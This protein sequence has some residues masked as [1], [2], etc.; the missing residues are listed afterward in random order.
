MRKIKYTFLLTSILCF[1]SC[2]SNYEDFSLDINQRSS[3]EELEEDI[4]DLYE[5]LEELVLT[6]NPTFQSLTNTE[7]ETIYNLSDPTVSST[8]DNHFN[9]LNAGKTSF[10]FTDA[11]MEEFIYDTIIKYHNARSIAVKTSF[12]STYSEDGTPCYDDYDDAMDAAIAIFTGGMALGAFT[13][14]PYVMLAAANTYT[15]AAVVAQT[16]WC[17]CMDE[18][19]PHAEQTPPGC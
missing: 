8:F 11:E 1:Y 2:D 17:I 4:I 10:G 12:E 5:Y 7:M 6:N 14:N 15:A 3:E 19:Y 13:L 18:T 9:N 16:V